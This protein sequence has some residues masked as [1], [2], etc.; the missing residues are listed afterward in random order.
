MP[1]ARIDIIGPV[2]LLEFGQGGDQVFRILAGQCRVIELP[3]AAILPVTGGAG[4]QQALRVAVKNK[5]QNCRIGVSIRC[6]R[7]RLL[8]SE[9]DRQ[10]RQLLVIKVAGLL[11]HVPVIA[12]L[13]LVVL[14]LFVNITA[15][16]PGDIDVFGII[17]DTGIAMAL[18]ALASLASCLAPRRVRRPQQLDGRQVKRHCR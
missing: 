16:Q 10:I 18:G 12:V 9:P 1:H 15:A 2:A 14:E 6:H 3:A 8:R 5:L 4:L 11:V 7:R 17:R 13:V